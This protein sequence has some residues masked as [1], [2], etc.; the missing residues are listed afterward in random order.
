MFAVSSL[1]GFEALALGAPVS[2]F[3]RSFYSG[4]GLTDDH[5]APTGRRGPAPLEAL[6]AALYVDYARYFDEA[7]RPCGLAEAL[8]ALERRR[9]CAL[10]TMARRS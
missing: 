7:R 3:G 6:A 1:L 2:C 4:W 8:D 9:D 5:A 10:R